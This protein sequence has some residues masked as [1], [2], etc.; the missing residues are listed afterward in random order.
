[1][2]KE[3][4]KLF[5]SIII[6]VS[7]FHACD[8]LNRSLLCVQTHFNAYH[9]RQYSCSMEQENHNNFFPSNA[10]FAYWKFSLF[11]LFLNTVECGIIRFFLQYYFPCMQRLLWDRACKERRTLL[12]K[13]KSPTNGHWKLESTRFFL[14]PPVYHCRENIHRD[15]DPF[16][17]EALNPSAPFQPFCCYDPF[18]WPILPLSTPFPSQFI[19]HATNAMCYA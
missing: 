13:K 8:P 9:C 16:S 10:L 5:G 2:Q 15:A 17:M 6:I 1:M 19:T 12:H 14:P 4:V 11:F 3:T 7:L 18:H